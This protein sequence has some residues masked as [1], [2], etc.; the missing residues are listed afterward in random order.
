MPKTLHNERARTSVRNRVAFRSIWRNPHANDPSRAAICVTCVAR[1]L[2]G[3]QALD[4]TKV[5][6]SKTKNSLIWVIRGTGPCGRRRRT[7]KNERGSA[8]QRP[9][10]QYFFSSLRLLRRALNS[11]AL[12]HLNERGAVD[13]KQYGS[14]F[15]VPARPLQCLLN[16]L[17]F[18]GLDCIAQVNA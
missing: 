11:L 2:T 4:T 15:F 13:A 17:V 10:F 6:Y 14:L 12:Q 8:P 7:T 3:R 9:P 5:S 16:E 1:C 18:K